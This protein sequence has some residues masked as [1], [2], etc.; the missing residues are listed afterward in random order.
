[1]NDTLEIT[2]THEITQADIECFNAYLIEGVE[3]WFKAGKL[4]VEMVE[5][6]PNAYSI[7]IR[8]NPHLSID[9]LLAFEKI[10]R[11]EIFPYVLLD[12]SPGSKRLLELPYELQA[13]Y[14]RE[15]LQVVT[16]A[17]DGTPVIEKKLANNL[18][19]DE[20]RI[21]FGP[22]GT[23]RT[24]EE[25]TALLKSDTRT[26]GVSRRTY[27]RREKLTGYVQ[28]ESD[29][30]GKITC[31]T[32]DYFPQRQTVKVLLPAGKESSLVLSVYKQLP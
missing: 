6:N 14:Y 10:G 21:V 13:K 19:K 22:N 11:R 1:M 31:K 30:A 23:I 26:N 2:K 4:L 8:N 7:I 5:R 27:S 18:T 12:K 9:L 32:I 28:V 29:K 25:Q 17:R 20:V 3:A 24:P 16:S 15:P